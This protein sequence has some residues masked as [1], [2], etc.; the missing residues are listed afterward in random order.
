MIPLI[1]SRGLLLSVA[2]VRFRIWAALAV[3]AI[4]A[5]LLCAQVSNESLGVLE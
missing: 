5:G 4:V 2:V 1:A 3:G